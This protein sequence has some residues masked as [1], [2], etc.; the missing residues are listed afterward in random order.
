LIIEAV[1]SPEHGSVDNHGTSL[2][3]TPDPDFS[4][5]DTLTYSVSD[6]NGGTGTATVII[7]VNP[8]NDAPLAQD[9]SAITDEDTLVSI[10]V[11]SN[12][13]DPDGDFLLVESV[14]S[15]SNGTIIN[16]ETSVSYIP[17]P[18]FNGIDVFTYIVSD[19]TGGTDTATVTIAISAVND[20]PTA[21][22]DSEAT[23]EE[24][25]VVIHV[26]PNDS[27][28]D[29]DTLVIQSLTQPS[30]GSTVKD[31][32][33][34]IYTPLPDFNG[35]D[36]FT[37]TISDGNGGTDTATVTIAVAAVNDP[38]S[39]QDDSDSTDEN[40]PVVIDV[41]PNDSD[42]DSDSLTV[43][44]VTQPDN[45]SVVNNGTDV[46]YI[47]D[48]EFSGIDVFT[49]TISD[50][51]GGTDTATVTIAVAAVNDPPSAQDDSD[52]TDEN[53]PV[54]IDVLPNDSD[55]DGDN[56]T[57]Q[58]V[59]QPDN[60]SVINNGTDILYTPNA[61]FNGVDI[62]TYTISDG[63][64]ETATA[65]V[66]VTVAAVNDP[67]IAQDD[68]DSTDEDTPAVI[69]VLPNDFDPDGDTLTVQSVT[70]PA[71]GTVANNGTDVVYTPD[72]AFNG[73]DV[74]TYTISDGSGGT[75]TATVTVAVAAINDPP[76]A[77]NDS[78]VTGEDAAVTILV[79][80]A[81]E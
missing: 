49:Y 59:T 1:T 6:G 77:L 22:D 48:S 20:P 9:D 81:S 54:N 66:A 71:N 68:S 14:S 17:N 3:Y 7:T 11:L 72:A 36:S 30:N 62:F 32:E 63:S 27:D 37:Y 47:P 18:G 75:A 46:T 50:G 58:S 67:P 29:G 42:P 57:V 12:D 45:G 55:P 51:N 34:L 10:P 73:I 16:A 23:D 25:P 61:D 40:T 41:L 60:G 28:P 31:G 79:L 2:T 69:D 56:L 33:T 21:L 39:A 8:T 70:Q 35:V 80:C 53:T 52:S 24:T 15:P 65:T 26:L 43:Q 4:G 19:G 74:F 5:T 38:P 44:S 78:V 76:V 64:G 13:S